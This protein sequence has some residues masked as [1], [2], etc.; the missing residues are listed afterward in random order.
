MPGLFQQ[1]AKDEEAGGWQRPDGAHARPPRCQSLMAGQAIEVAAHDA[2]SI[3]CSR[4]AVIRNVANRWVRMF[5]GLARAHREEAALD[6]PGSHLGACT[7]PELGQD[8]L[9]VFGRR[10]LGHASSVAIQQLVRPRATSTATCRSRLVRRPVAAGLALRHE[11]QASGACLAHSTRLTRSAPASLSRT[12]A[13]IR[14]SPPSQRAVM[15]SGPPRP[16]SAC[17]GGARGIGACAGARGGQVHALRIARARHA[18]GK[19]AA[20][21]RADANSGELPACHRARRRQV[22]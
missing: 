22:P 13:R 17:S 7:Q 9:D 18:Q 4:Q 2:A 10:G 15:R 1:P 14:A 12:R 21:L 19:R 5:L 8:V 20:V 3:R 11:L 16:L 6:R